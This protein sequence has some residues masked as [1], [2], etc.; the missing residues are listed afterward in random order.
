MG[1]DPIFE[2]RKAQGIPT[3][4]EAAAKVIAAYSKTWRNAKHAG[5]W[6]SNPDRKIQAQ[7]QSR[8]TWAA[9]EAAKGEPTA[10]DYGMGRA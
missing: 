3:F 10:H 6:S 7:V 9:V 2:G 5:Q 4:R 8:E 1:L